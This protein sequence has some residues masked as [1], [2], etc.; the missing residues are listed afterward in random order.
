MAATA[1]TFTSLLHK[2][3]AL[4][5][6]LSDLQRV[7]SQPVTDD[8]SVTARTLLE[9]M[10]TIAAQVESLQIENGVEPREIESANLYE[11]T[12]ELTELVNVLVFI[13]EE[14]ATLPD[15]SAQTLTVAEGETPTLET[16]FNCIGFIETQV[17]V[18]EVAWEYNELK[19]IIQPLYEAVGNLHAD[20]GY[21]PTRVWN[22]QVRTTTAM[23]PDLS[24]AVQNIQAN[25]ELTIGMLGHWAVYEDHFIV[26]DSAGKEL[27]R[28]PLVRDAYRDIIQMGSISAEG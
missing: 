1:L 27:T 26:Y 28:I 14:I 10:F 8:T 17:H 2:L 20:L 16:I 3:Q 24:Q 7:L 19:E 4:S 6:V 21:L 22:Y 9:A 5:D 25:Q 13:S 12:P 18:L 11:G 15:A 23:S